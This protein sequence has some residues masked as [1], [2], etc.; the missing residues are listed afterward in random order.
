MKQYDVACEND[1]A[2]CPNPSV[3]PRDKALLS[4]EPWDPVLN[5]IQEWR[6]RDSI[7]TSTAV[8]D[9]ERRTRIL[10]RGTSSLIKRC[11][12]DGC[13][14]DCTMTTCAPR[15]A[16]G[17][18]RWRRGAAF[19][20]LAIAALSLPQVPANAQARPADSPRCLGFARDGC[21]PR[22][23]AAFPRVLRITDV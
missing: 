7:C 3:L 13:R 8:W 4:D 2:S 5:E 22:A 11:W 9:S 16:R 19:A 18:S 6:T 20:L 23:A 21:S 15:A 1:H 10:P 12:S 17:A 14:R